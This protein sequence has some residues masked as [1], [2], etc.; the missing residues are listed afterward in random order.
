MKIA[1]VEAT[2]LYVTFDVDLLGLDRSVALSICFVE[3]ETDDGVT[4]HG[5][6]AITDEMAVAAAVNH[7]A[8]PYILGDDPMAH[9]ETRKA[10]SLSDRMRDALK[11][12]PMDTQEL[13]ELLESTDNTIRSNL[14]RFPNDFQRTI[15]GKIALQSTFLR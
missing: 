14:R 1:R 10:F 8:A 2:P 12:G 6:T 9:E 11:D 15:D 5:I 3:V 4:G 13:A 7:V